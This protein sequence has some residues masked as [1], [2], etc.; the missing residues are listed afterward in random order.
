MKL[1]LQNT[2]SVKLSS[3]PSANSNVIQTVRRTNLIEAINEV[4]DDHGNQWWQVE[5]RSSPSDPNPRKGF[6][7]ATFLKEKTDDGP[8]IVLDRKGF[9][10]SLSFAAIIYGSNRDYLAVVAQIESSM[11]NIRDTSG[12]EAI[13][14]FQFTPTIW[15]ELLTSM[16]DKDLTNEAIARPSTQALV[17]VSYTHLTLP[18]NR[19]V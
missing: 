10:R 1:T 6:I 16:E 9:I 8:L 19:E 7:L 4:I 15:A 2:A 14:P 12:S 18:T 3:E 11:Q 5:V 17:A 13:G